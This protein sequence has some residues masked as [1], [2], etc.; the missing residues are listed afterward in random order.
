MEN[1]DLESL[2]AMGASLVLL[3]PLPSSLVLD[4]WEFCGTY[5]SLQL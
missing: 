4:L 5:G 1:R 3:I 2:K